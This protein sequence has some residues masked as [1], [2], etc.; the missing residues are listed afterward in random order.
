[1]YIFS[2]LKAARVVAIVGQAVLTAFAAYLFYLCRET[3]IVENVGG[4]SGFMGIHLKADS[5]SSLFVALTTFVFCVAAIYCFGENSSKLFWFLLFIW[6]GLLIGIFLTRDLFNIFVLVE[7]VT[8]VVA[9]LIMY[10][11]DNRSMYDGMF[12]L[13]VCV[14]A[15]QFFLFGVGYIYKLT[16]V[17][18]IEAAAEALKGVDRNSLVLPYALIIT[19]ISLKCALLPLYNWL[20][21]AHGTPGAPS[22]VS[23]LLSGVHIKG[24]VY[25]F[26]R[27]QSL[28]SEIDTSMIFLVI[29]IVTG[30]AGFI[31]AI[32]QSDIKLIL[33]YH[34]ISQVG[35]IM[36][37][38][39]I[40]D[41]YAYTGGLY[42][43]FN[44]AIF[45]SALF[46]CAG[47]IIKVYGTRN[48]YEIR[49][50]LRR[51]PF[52]GVATF[53]AVLGIT[54]APL[55]NGSISKYFIMSGTNLLVSSLLIFINLGTIISFIKYSKMLFGRHEGGED[56]VVY[57]KT[58]EQV[59]VMILGTL[60]FVGGIFGEQFIAFL[61]NVQI[62]VDAAGYIEKTLLYA[63][64]LVAGYLIF[65]YYVQ[66]S[67]LLKR[68]RTIDV[69]FRG[70][71]IL[72]GGFFAAMVIAIR[73][74]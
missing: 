56:G 63:A 31:R 45:K 3:E 61:F 62:S 27:T 67:A 50:V 46:F 25:L 24:G 58:C 36:A 51:L 19:A 29:G 4:F 5:L 38:L 26:I 17:L 8:I 20:P 14:V 71:C 41:S 33:A 15:M 53:M 59:A 13:M 12:Y 21:K 48:I 74:M 30:I 68:L 47:I 55:F 32:T 28:F 43:A 11:R 52:V 72:M 1:M 39:N 60:C 70:M 23:A 73:F 40:G 34:T 22:A 37:S 16:G 57:A 9:V 64:S 49:G 69:G 35:M 66:K 44:H 7:V 2:S 42:H 65:K 6:E 18:D 10:C 54:G